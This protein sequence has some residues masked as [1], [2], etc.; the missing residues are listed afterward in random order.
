MSPDTPVRSG[1]EPDSNPGLVLE[2]ARLLAE[3]RASLEELSRSRTRILAVADETRAQI[4]RDLH[5][6]TQ[7][8]L[9][10]LRL[11]L[12]AES[13]RLRAE[14]PELAAI[15]EQ[16]GTEIE[17]AIDEMRSLARGVYPAMLAGHGLAET[18]RW[19]ALDDPVVVSVHV[20]GVGRYD[21]EVERAVYFACLEALQNA[22][23]HAG[24][25]HRV[26]ISL[27]DDDGLRFEVR[28][29]GAG[30]GP[31]TDGAGTGLL[32]IRDRMAAVGGVVQ[33]DSAPG[34][35]TTVRGWVPHPA[36]MVA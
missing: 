25:A 9:F 24:P 33:V 29:D 10:L 8:H 17:D 34:Q 7:Q 3:L 30:L 36:A 23:K 13:E 21:P 12:S 35:G 20:E 4:G 27:V 1:G 22:S 6:G 11:R 16:L 14:Q 31:D 32:N 5:D 2:N 19:A 26:W 28:D 15:L 18:L